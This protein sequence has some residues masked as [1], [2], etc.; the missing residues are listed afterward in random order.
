M[1]ERDEHK[2]Q[3][4]DEN[5]AS[6]I[7]LTTL[8]GRFEE[9]NAAYSAL[10]GYSD[11]L[12]K[13]QLF[14]LI[15]PKDLDEFKRQI[16]LLGRESQFEIRNRYQ[17]KSGAIV[18]VRSFVSTVPDAEGKPGRIIALLTDITNRMRTQE[19]LRAAKAQLRMLID[20]APAT[21]AM[22]DRDI[23]YAA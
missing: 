22:F 11:E 2:F 15:H 8:D 19:Q 20:H 4:I 3:K 13:T 9:C 5:I 16:E 12:R 10:T 23:R 21:V 1:S 7:A 17:A 14:S 18:W 6:G